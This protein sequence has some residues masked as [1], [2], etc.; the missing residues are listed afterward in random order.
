MTHP[1]QVGGGHGQPAEQPRLRGRRDRGL[2]DQA[3]GLV[4]G[5]PQVLTGGVENP[6]GLLTQVLPGIGERTRRGRTG[7]PE[8]VAAWTARLYASTCRL[9]ASRA[10]SLACSPSR[11][12]RMAS[13]ASRCACSS[14][15]RYW[16]NAAAAWWNASPAACHRGASSVK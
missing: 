5:L 8:A 16:R 3:S 2:P 10:A 6:L 13:A 14:A 12:S 9:Y 11:Y 7:P 15:S 4:P 1:D